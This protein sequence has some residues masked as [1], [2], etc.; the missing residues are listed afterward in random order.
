MRTACGQ[1]CGTVAQLALP[2]A[3]GILVSMPQMYTGSHA[4]SLSLQLC[5]LR[6]RAGLRPRVPTTLLRETVRLR[7]WTRVLFC[8]ELK[9]LRLIPTGSKYAPTSDQ[10]DRDFYTQLSHA[11]ETILPAAKSD[12]W[13]PV[14]TKEVK[15]EVDSP[16]GFCST[17]LRGCLL[18]GKNKVE[19]EGLLT[20]KLTGKFVPIERS[21]LF[22]ERTGI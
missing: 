1:P 8:P 19:R 10:C 5:L 4:T 12:L 20:V 16:G 13:V 7:P 3:S 9:V 18:F 22:D 2:V 11:G 6:E 21:E 14:T 17:F 15:A